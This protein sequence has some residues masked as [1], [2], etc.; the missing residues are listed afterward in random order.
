MLTELLESDGF[1]LARKTTSEM[2]STCPWCGGSDRFT[3]FLGEGR[4]WCRQCG[5][6]GDGI[7]YLVDFHRM[8]FPA[9][10]AMVG[11]DIAVLTGKSR[12]S[13]PSAPTLGHIEPVKAQPP[14]WRERAAAGIQRAHAALMKNPEA[15]NWLRLE[16]GVTVETVQR[17]KLGWLAENHFFP[18]SEFG[19]P[20]DGK[21]LVIPA[22]LLIPWKD[23]RIRVRRSNDEDAK[24]YGRYYV[25]PGSG[26]EPMT[27]GT[28]SE[29][30]AVI[31]ESELDAILLSQEIRRKTY[32]VAIGSAQVK[33]RFELLSQLN[34]CPAVLV[35]LD[36]DVAGAK[37]AQWWPENVP[38]CHRTLT[39]SQFGKDFGE[40]FKNGLDLNLWISAAMTIVA[41][42]L[43]TKQG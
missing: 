3:V 33:A 39:P 13:S 17:F 30:T 36:N 20:D 15:L 37:A 12:S 40:A 21:K 22:G 18:K 1:R 23:G 14:L 9:A 8:A 11:K 34:R 24:K 10:A 6:H 2:S 4:Y 43:T 29:T 35:A 27:I 26:T 19:L 31:V 25:L 7:Q 32:I 38:G 42:I 28:P 16:R 5:K 41:E